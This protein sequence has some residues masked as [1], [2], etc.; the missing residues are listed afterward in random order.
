[1]EGRSGREVFSTVSR[2]GAEVAQ[3]GLRILAEIAVR[4]VVV[5][6]KQLNEPRALLFLIRPFDPDQDC[7][8]G[9]ESQTDQFHD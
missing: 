9:S 1:M 5:C 3:D 2:S 4:K 8:T 6:F 7:R